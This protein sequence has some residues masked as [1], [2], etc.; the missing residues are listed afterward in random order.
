MNLRALHHSQASDAQ[1]LLKPN[2][3]PAC[4]CTQLVCLGP[5]VITAA[6]VTVPESAHIVQRLN[7]HYPCISRHNWAH[8]IVGIAMLIFLILCMGFTYS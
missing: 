3:P 5:P 4:A 8:S 6:L 1:F 2:D 7:H